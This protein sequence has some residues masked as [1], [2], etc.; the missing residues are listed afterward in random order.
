[1]AQT[2]SMLQAALA[3]HHFSA[4]SCIRCGV[5]LSWQERNVPPGNTPCKAALLSSQSSTQIGR[6]LNRTLLDHVRQHYRHRPVA[7]HCA[8]SRLCARSLACHLS[9]PVSTPTTPR[10]RAASPMCSA[11]SSTPRRVRLLLRVGHERNRLFRCFF[12]MRERIRYNPF[13]VVSCSSTLL[14]ATA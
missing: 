4:R 6:K 7:C 2:S 12:G 1:M 3:T 5:P 11:R 14:R 10:S 9:Q 8:V 13:I